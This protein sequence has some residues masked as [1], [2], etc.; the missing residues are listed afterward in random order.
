MNE[1]IETKRE[2]I[3]VIEWKEQRVITTSLLAE[4]YGASKTQIK[5][6]FNNNEEH[7]EVGKHYYLLKGKELKEFKDLVDNIYLVDKRAPQLYLWTERGA[8]RHCKILDTD[9][10]WEQF[11]NLE[12]TY[13]KV[14]SHKSRE[15]LEAV[16]RAADILSGAYRAAGIDERY[17]AI[18]VGSV[19]KEFDICVALPPI[20]MDSDKLYDQTMIAR[21][22]GIVSASGK[23]HA[24]AVGAIINQLDI[25]D[26]YK[27]ST[28]YMNHG[29]SGVS[30]QYKEN[31]CKMVN[32][33][34]EDNHYPEIIKGNGKSYSVVYR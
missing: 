28:P 13:F 8:N 22:L 24:Q 12:E 31:V 1:I 10:A 21:E 17:L 6:N 9:K 15:S 34:L 27:I 5:Q 25:S 18:L 23:P 11:D 2:S 32:Q 30:V 19:Y 26:E 33:W 4:V 20:E 14:K 7:F 29:H 16:N 3:P